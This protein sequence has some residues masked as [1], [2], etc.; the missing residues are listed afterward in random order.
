MLVA[1]TGQKFRFTE[2]DCISGD[3]KPSLRSKDLGPSQETVVA[4]GDD[5]TKLGTPE[6]SSMANS[7]GCLFTKP[8][9]DYPHALI[10]L[11]GVLLTIE[12]AAIL[13]LSLFIS[14]VYLINKWL[15]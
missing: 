2:D 4:E 10:G 9:E 15:T 1:R 13:Q 8:R 11:L 6:Y 12:G 3:S 7:L 14:G 5:F